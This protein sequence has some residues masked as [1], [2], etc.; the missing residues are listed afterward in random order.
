M[1]ARIASSSTAAARGGTQVAA[2]SRAGRT[3][4]A[5]GVV[6]PAGPKASHGSKRLLAS[7]LFGAPVS[8]RFPVHAARVPAASMATRAAAGPETE[9]L[10]NCPDAQVKPA[11]PEIALGTADTAPADFE[12]DLLAL[13][14]FEEEAEVDEEGALKSAK[15]KELDAAMGGIISE[16]VAAEE[17]KG[18]EGSSVFAR[19]GGKA[20]Y[21]GLV[22][23]GKAEAPPKSSSFRALGAAIAAEAKKSKAVSAGYAL[24]GAPDYAAADAADAVGAVAGGALLG[25][26]ETLRFKTEPKPSKLAKLEALGVA[27]AAEAAAAI[28]TAKAFASGTSLCRELVAAPPNYVTPAELARVAERIAAE[29]SDVMSVKI[30]EQA[31]C[32]ALG[33]GSYLGVAAA[34]LPPKFIHLTYTAPG[35]AATKLGVVGKG[36]TFDC[37]GYNIKAGAGSMIEMMKFDMGGS[38]ATLGAARAVAEL[39]P[40]GVEVHFIVA[41]CENMID[42][43]GMRPG[44][45]LTASNGKTIE[46]NNTDAEGRLTLADALVYAEKQGVTKC[47]DIATLTGA[48][49]VALGDGIGGMFTPEDD[50]ADELMAAS[51]ATGEKLWR[52][53]MEESYMEQMKSPIA[54]LRN[55]GMGKGGAITAALFLKEFAG[56]ME[57][58]HLD[59]AGPVWSDKAGGA[60]GFGAACLATW[61]SSNS[62]K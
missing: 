50:L 46:V 3:S 25:A 33:M 24:V 39:R 17:F 14:I 13:A 35:G 53:P 34:G 6:A 29:F 12:G 52:M 15:L 1:A 37:G 62:K 55:T 9:F 44:D 57:W 19:L 59:I 40:A 45:I 16:M 41:A 21:V 38:G 48:C 60:T 58:A 27:P 11:L 8:A 20:K 22:G 47:V 26:Y 61:V 54:D 51:K 23:M 56:E 31:E 2:A 4:V 32:E 5:H 49:M 30:L 36:L 18:K 43:V 10:L 28:A 7:Q 42:K